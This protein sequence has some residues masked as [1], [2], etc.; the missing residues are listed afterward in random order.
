MP[1]AEVVSVAM[2]ALGDGQCYTASSDEKGLALGLEL[3]VGG[4]NTVVS[5]AVVGLDLSRLE[6]RHLRQIH[7]ARA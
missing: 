2:L 4:C 3:G 7:L 1:V 6:L 5:L